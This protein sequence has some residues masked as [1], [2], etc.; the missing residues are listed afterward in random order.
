[1][2]IVICVDRLTG[3]GAQRVAALWAQGFV[4]YGHEVSMVL[5]NNRAPVTYHVPPQVRMFSV[6]FDIK[7]GYV[8]YLCKSLFLI[9]K[10]RRIFQSVQPDVVIGVGIGWAQKI[11]KARGNMKF[12]VVMTDHYSYER[13]SSA[14]SPISDKAHQLRFE[15]NKRFDAVTV[16]TQADKEY[17]GERLNNVYV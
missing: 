14:T 10:L 8:R 2:K 6:D 7:N 12:K 17:I 11:D 9:K 1:M 5:S 3:G 15:F 16:L 4:K 13:P